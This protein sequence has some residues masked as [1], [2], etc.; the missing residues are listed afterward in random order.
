MKSETKPTPARRAETA[1]KGQVFDI[2]QFCIHDGPGIRTTVFLKGC[3]L[4]CLWCHNP[5]SISPT[6]EISFTPSKCIGCGYCFRV[7]PVGAHRMEGDQRVYDRDKCTACGKCTQECY[8]GAL[9]LAGREMSVGEVMSEVLKDKPFYETSNGGMTLSGGEPLAQPKFTKALLAAAKAEGL[10]T[11]VDTSG[12]ATWEQHESILPLVDLFLFDIKCL[13]PKR[14]KALTGVDIGPIQEN[15]GKLDASGAAY[16]LRVPAV[17][18]VNLVAGFLEALA[19]LTL[20]LNNCRGLEILPYHG[21]ARSKYERFGKEY[22]LAVLT[23]PTDEEADGWI[24]TLHE[25]GI[26]FARRS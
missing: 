3:S 24:R 21:M 6:P 4:R 16:L 8:A 17:P 23:T 1:R 26:S 11:C 14:H 2:Q 18:G 9:E 19:A 22:S 12:G 15:L 10:H 25:L 13:D 7:C 20:S 5:E